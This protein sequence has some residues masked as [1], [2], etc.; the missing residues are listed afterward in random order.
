MAAPSTGP[1]CWR[2]C[3]ADSWQTRWD[4]DAYRLRMQLDLMD[5]ADDYLVLADLASQGR[6]A[7]RSAAW[8]WTPG[9]AKG[10]LGKGAE[11]RRAAEVPRR[12]D[13]AG[14]RRPRRAWPLPARAPAVA[15]AR[16]ATNTFNTGLALVTS[17]Q[18]DTGPGADE[19]GPGR[20]A[21]RPGAGRLQYATGPAQGRADGRG[22]RTVQGAVDA[23]SRW[24]CWPG[25]GRPRCR[26]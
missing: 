14:G 23:T 6:P 24:A 9:W 5:E 2:A 25:S 16:S 11:G 22:R 3:S 12:H 1:T 15:D 10:L 18:A 13:Q 20:P 26:R 8:C 7:G 4:V 21:A 19:G 17:G